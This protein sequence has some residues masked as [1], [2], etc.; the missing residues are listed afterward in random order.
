[1]SAAGKGV[2]NGLTE[3]FE[4]KTKTVISLEAG[5]GFFLLSNIAAVKSGCNL[6]NF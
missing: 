3:S 4:S 5:N 6:L 1:L 2:D